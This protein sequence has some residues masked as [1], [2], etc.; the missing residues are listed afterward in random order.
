MRR[1]LLYAGL[2][3][4]IAACVAVGTY[5]LAAHL[6]TLPAPSP[7]DPGFHQAIAAHRHANQRGRWLVLH[8]VFDECKCSQQVLEHL[9]AAPRPP[10]VAE[11]IILVTEHRASAADSISAI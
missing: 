8:V 7:A 1:V 11:R 6:L 9:L 4:W 3:G 2:V 5:L 10:G